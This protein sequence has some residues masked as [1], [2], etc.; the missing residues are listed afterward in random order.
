VLHQIFERVSIVLDW[1]IEC[2]IQI[3]S[4]TSSQNRSNPSSTLKHFGD[5]ANIASTRMKEQP[6]SL[7][8][9]GQRLE[10]ARARTKHWKRWGRYLGELHR[11]WRSLR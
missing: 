2:L 1:N 8:A 7:T 4:K 6:Q 3:R 10:E 11:F 9:E 5:R